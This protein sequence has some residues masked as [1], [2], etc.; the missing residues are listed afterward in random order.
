M[1]IIEIA[2]IKIQIINKY[3]YLEKLCSDYI[4]DSPSFDFSISVSDEEIEEEKKKD[5]VNHTNGY[6]ESICLYRKICF[7]LIKYDAFV[8]HACTIKIDNYAYLLSAKSGTGKTTHSRLIKEY[9]GDRMTYING[10]K[11]IIRIFNGV[12]YA[13]GTPWNGKERYGEN[14]NAQVKAIVFIERAKENSIELINKDKLLSKIINQILIPNNEEG[15]TKTF[16]LT[17]ILLN[18]TKQYILKCN[19]DISAAICS[20]NAITKG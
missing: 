1:F 19:M 10:D 2:K 12:P 5:E 9:L 6:L 4:V 11:P 17:D 3:K 15:V 14:T 20:Y 18:N 8:I 7:E 13:F 16:M